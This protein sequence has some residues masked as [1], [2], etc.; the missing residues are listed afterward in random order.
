MGTVCKKCCDFYKDVNNISY[1]DYVEKYLLKDNFNSIKDFEY[2][3]SLHKISDYLMHADNYKI[4]HSINDYLTNQKQL[5]QLKLYTGKK[6][7]LFDNGSHLGFLY[8]KEFID[9]L[10]SDA[11]NKLKSY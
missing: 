8:R 1:K 5:K 11:M 2:Q 3:T 4:Y 10:K 7:V 6:T 9:E